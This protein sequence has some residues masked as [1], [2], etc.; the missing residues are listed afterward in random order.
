[1][2]RIDAANLLATE[3]VAQRREDW[4]RRWRSPVGLTARR[5]ALMRHGVVERSFKAS[6]LPRMEEPNGMMSRR[7][8]SSE[9][10]AVALVSTTTTSRPEAHRLS[11]AASNREYPV[12]PKE[13]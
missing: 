3:T 12:R 11:P 2:S 1:M 13:G 9:L 8:F 10:V 7:M 4:C 5:R 6:A